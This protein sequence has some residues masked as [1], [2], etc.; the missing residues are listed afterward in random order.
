VPLAVQ[1]P[2]TNVLA[3]V[4]VGDEPVQTPLAE[5]DS[6]GTIEAFKALL[7]KGNPFSSQVE[8]WQTRQDGADSQASRASKGKCPRPGFA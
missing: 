5:E 3:K 7:V 6:L 2:E 8:P 4:L 1:T